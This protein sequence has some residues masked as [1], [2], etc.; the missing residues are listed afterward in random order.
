MTLTSD[1][2]LRCEAMIEA[3]FDAPFTIQK[4]T[5]STYLALFVLL[6]GDPAEIIKRL[7]HL[8][9]RYLISAN[10]AFI[11]MK[12]KLNRMNAEMPDTIAGAVANMEDRIR[13]RR[14]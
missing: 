1:D 12:N 5:A 8:D 11:D 7:A 14:R 3:F 10:D 9:D 4:D 2:A 13:A 6:G